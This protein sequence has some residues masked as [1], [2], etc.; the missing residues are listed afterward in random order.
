MSKRSADSY[1]SYDQFRT[2][3]T[4]IWHCP[5]CN[6]TKITFDATRGE[7]I[8]SNCGLVL[9]DSC[10]DPS[11]DWRAYNKE[12]NERRART[13]APKNL[14]QYDPYGTVIDSINRDAYGKSLSPEQ[15]NQMGRLRTLQKR[16]GNQFGME[17]SLMKALNEL[18]RIGSQLSLTQ[19]I[20]ETAAIIYRKLLKLGIV[21]GRSTE[22]LVSASLYLSC[23]L[24]KHP[25]TLEEIASHTRLNRKKLAKN[26]RLLLNTL[27]FKMPLD[28][29]TTKLAKFASELNMPTNIVNGAEEI[30][31]RAKEEKITIGKNPNS[32]A[33]AALY[34]AAL[35]NNINCS[36]KEV[37]AV[38]QIT[39]VTLRNRYKEF[40]K[41]LNIR[42]RKE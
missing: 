18:K 16:V 37:A 3:T 36:Q 24:H 35:R 39:E 26:F 42:I 34:I 33:A 9:E 15:V 19:K 29:P 27:E 11:Q 1:S 38:C 21:R 32:L 8:C 12:Q 17:R 20:N 41:K 22:A 14:L 40:I 31:K 2:E 28:T 4:T 23:R 30:L 5:E 13:G 10:I 7:F 25:I 6:G